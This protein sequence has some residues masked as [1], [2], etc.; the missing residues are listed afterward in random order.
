MRGLA[1]LALGRRGKRNAVDAS[2]AVRPGSPWAGVGALALVASFLV[3]S[4]YAVCPLTPRGAGHR[5]SDGGD[6][7]LA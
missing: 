5:A 7:R 3:L 6:C 2:L 4:Y 1:E